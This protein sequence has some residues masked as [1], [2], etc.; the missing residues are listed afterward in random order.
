MHGLLLS[1]KN[2]VIIGDILVVAG[3]LCWSFRL[4][5]AVRVTR[6]VSRPDKYCCTSDSDQRVYPPFNQRKKNKAP[7]R[8]VVGIDSLTKLTFN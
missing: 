2:N 1:V 5:L 3:E 6:F 4:A 8:P 7:I